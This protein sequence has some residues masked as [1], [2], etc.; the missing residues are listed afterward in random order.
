MGG[1]AVPPWRDA[2]DLGTFRQSHNHLLR[3]ESTQEPAY[4]HE[5]GFK[6]QK[7]TF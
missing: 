1:G 3:W 5:E 7:N 4:G 6:E 2:T